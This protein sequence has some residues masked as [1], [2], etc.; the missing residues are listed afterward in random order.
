MPETFF[1]GDT[2][3]SHKRII[4]FEPVHRPFATIDEHD[5]ELIRR[6]NAKVSTNDTVFH[7]GDFSFGGRDKVAIAANLNGNKKL[8]LGNHDMKPIELYLQHF[9]RVAG[10]LE[11][12]GH[13]L[14]HIPVHVDQLERYTSNIHGHLHSKFAY[15][16]LYEGNRHWNVSC[17]QINCTPISYD[18]LKEK[19]SG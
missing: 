9:T 7:L 2:H 8:I 10:A 11:W 13:I 15:D 1:I 12:K 14:T 4:E 6:W 3:F 16:D 17:E 18:E 5:E 19:Y